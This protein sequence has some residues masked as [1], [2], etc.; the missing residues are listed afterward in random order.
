M[1]PR[2]SV[3]IPTYNAARFV[4][5]AIDSALG[6]TL[7]PL[8]VIVVDDGSTD[9]TERVLESYGDRIRVVRQS[10]G[11]P[12]AARNRGIQESK[13][14]LIAFLDHDDVWLAEKLKKQWERLRNH[15]GAGLV[16]SNYFSW[17]EDTGEM[18]LERDPSDDH[19]GHCYVKTFMNNSIIPSVVMIKRECLDRVGPF[20][21]SILPASADDYDLFLRLA[22]HYEFAYLN[23]P[24]TLYRLH[25]SNASNAGLVMATK[26]LLVVRKCLSDDPN[27]S[28]LAGRSR[29]RKRFHTL[30][31][32]IGYH[33][34]NGYRR[35]EARRFFRQ[36][37]LYQPWRVYTLSL[38]LANFLPTP[39]TR[40]LRRFKDGLARMKPTPSRAKV[41]RIAACPRGQ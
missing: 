18:V 23:E 17:R 28:R 15:P 38:Y 7:A 26:T 10:N 31:F 2:I 13:G 1:E 3:I 11:G 24:L 37:L 9:E 34:H 41:E 29:V 12:A 21:E 33:H 4:A 39:W 32:D 27:L 19:S 14:N 35:A 30:M 22:R 5:E 8:E 36:A 40:A 16:H 25:S 6:Q 20:D